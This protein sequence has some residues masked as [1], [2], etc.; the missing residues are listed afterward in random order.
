MKS[1]KTRRFGSR[2]NNF[3]RYS[4]QIPAKSRICP[5]TAGHAIDPRI[6]FPNPSPQ[7]ES[8][9]IS[10]KNT[11]RPDSWRSRAFDV[12]GAGFEPA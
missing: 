6:A 11:R 5:E 4:P 7:R 10:A 2:H 12:A 8:T 9:E 1:Q 3:P